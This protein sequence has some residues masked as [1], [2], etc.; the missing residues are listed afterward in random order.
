[1]KMYC[2]LIVWYVLPAI[3]SAIAVSMIKD[4]KLR[5]TEVAKKLGVT[6]AA[7][8]QYLSLKRAKITIRDPKILKQVK[9]STKRIINGNDNVIFQETCRL[10]EILKNSKLMSELYKTYS[11]GNIPD[12]IACLNK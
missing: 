3:R 6:D 12:N 1:M 5:Q 9:V 7:V 8:S 4:Y 2:E 10:C 11:D